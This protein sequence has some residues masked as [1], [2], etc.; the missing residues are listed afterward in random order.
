KRYRSC[1]PRNQTASGGS[2]GKY[3]GKN[4]GGA[5]VV[6]TKK[7]PLKLLSCG[8]RTCE[9]W[10]LNFVRLLASA[11]QAFDGL[12]GIFPLFLLKLADPTGH[13]GHHVGRG[14]AGRFAPGAH[15]GWFVLTAL[16]ALDYCYAF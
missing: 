9:E 7:R 6:S 4:N 13:C 12:G 10:P 16:F 14:L 3:A 8:Y 15:T 1:R 5:L 11:D 2:P